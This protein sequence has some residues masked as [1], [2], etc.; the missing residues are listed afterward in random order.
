MILVIGATAPF[1]RETVEELLAAGQE[2][3]ALTR[4]PDEAKLPA[5]VQIVYGDLTRP[6]T[7]TDAVKDV[8][9]IALVLPYGLDPT[10]LLGVVAPGT[11]IVFLSSGAIDDAVSPQRDVIAAYHAG[12]EHAITEATTDWTFLRLFFPAINSLPYAMQL[13]SGDVLRVPYAEATS[14][15]VHERDV[16]EAAA[17]I[18]ADGGHAGRTYLLTGPRSDTQSG[19]IKTLGEQLGRDLTVEDLDPEPVLKQ[20]SQFMDPDFI[21][22]LFALMAGTVSNPAQV[23]SAVADITGHPARGYEQWVRDHAAS[24]GG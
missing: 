16:A 22:A 1:G 18:L 12:V 14:A 10:P 13:K 20:M 15:P 7:L 17:R 6:E 23:T 8:S 24:F 5:G 4:K 2:V 3:R 9:A 11:R 21:A 19:L